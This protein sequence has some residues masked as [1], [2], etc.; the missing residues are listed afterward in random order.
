MSYDPPTLSEVKA[1]LQK[2]FADRGMEIRGQ[3]RIIVVT[4]QVLSDAVKKSVVKECSSFAVVFF[5]REYF[6]SHIL[7]KS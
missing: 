4:E 6:D 5:T 3:D 1:A 2:K 7:H